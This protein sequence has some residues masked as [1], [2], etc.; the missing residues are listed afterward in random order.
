MHLW[1]FDL[2]PKAIGLTF[3]AKDTETLFLD[4]IPLRYNNLG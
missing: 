3:A 1:R 2:E 4:L